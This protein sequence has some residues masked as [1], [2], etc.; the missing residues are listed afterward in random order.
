MWMTDC[1]EMAGYKGFLKE[2]ANIC[3]SFLL[4]LWTLLELI[5]QV[6]FYKLLEIISSTDIKEKGN[7]Q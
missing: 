7:I 5:W 1:H 4:K 3:K 6:S 2:A